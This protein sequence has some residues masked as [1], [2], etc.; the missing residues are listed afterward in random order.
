MTKHEVRKENGVETMREK[1][2]QGRMRFRVFEPPTAP[3]SE[4]SSIPEHP[5]ILAEGHMPGGEVAK[6]DSLLVLTGIQRG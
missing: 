4:I 1:A 6:L 3:I 2:P 5:L